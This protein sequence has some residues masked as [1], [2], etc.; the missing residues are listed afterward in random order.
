MRFK[1]YGKQK[2]GDYSSV[3]LMF[4]ASIAVG[5]AFGYFLDKQFETEPVFLIIF[6]LYGVAAGF[7]NLIKITRTPPKKKNNKANENE[8][9]KES[10]NES[11]NELRLA[12][13][14]HENDPGP[15]ASSPGK[16]KK[17]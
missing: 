2:L 5:L 15:I 8:T 9:G 12:G 7:W 14:N 3:G 17:K 4:P 10:G 16:L 1:R 6:T 11:G 13:K